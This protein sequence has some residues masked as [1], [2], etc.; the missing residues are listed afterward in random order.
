MLCAL[1]DTHGPPRTRQV[2]CD[3]AFEVSD[4]VVLALQVAPATTAGVLLDERLELR[5]DGDAGA[6][7]ATELATDHGGR[8]HLLRSGSGRL[9]ITYRASVAPPPDPVI[10]SPRARVRFDPNRTADMEAIL[11]LRQSRYCPSDTLA[12]FAAA[13][14]VDAAER[15]DLAWEIASWVFER[16]AYVE[17][18]SGPL[19]TA[20]DILMQGAGVCRDFAHLTVTLCRALGVPARLRAAYAPGL[21]PMD[22]H[23]VVEARLADG[24]ETLDATRLAP[25][26][27]LVTIATGRDAADTAFAT[28]LHGQAVLIATEV[29]AVVDGDLPADDHARVIISS[30]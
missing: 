29:F 26:T 6:A 2:G 21:S 8:I 1:T 27:S 10:P 24:W 30:P 12:G 18:S 14:F 20:T 15:G 3:L 25:R 13:Q 17:G 16:L 19:D 11:A 23:A 22:V 4:D 9:D 5:V 7:S 28:T